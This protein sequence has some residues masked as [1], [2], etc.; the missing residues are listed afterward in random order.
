[1]TAAGF[2]SSANVKILKIKKDAEQIGDP[3]EIDLTR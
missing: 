3:N 1:M 2:W